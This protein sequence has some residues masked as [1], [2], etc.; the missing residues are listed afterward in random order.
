MHPK[1]PYSS[2][3]TP[4]IKMGPAP[5]RSVDGRL[6]RSLAAPKSRGWFS[7]PSR[8]TPPHFSEA[9]PPPP[10]GG[11][12]I[13]SGRPPPLWRAHRRG[14]GM[15]G[16]RGPDWVGQAAPT[17]PS[18]PGIAWWGDPTAARRARKPPFGLRLPRGG[19]PRR[20]RGDRRQA[21]GASRTAA[22]QSAAMANRAASAA[23]IGARPPAGAD[24]DHPWA[25]GFGCSLFL[26]GRHGVGMPR[27]GPPP[28]TPPQ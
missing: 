4:F 9:W 8:A 24:A 22:A 12:G 27:S 13:G 23:L 11:G 7:A 28:P 26:G 25:I 1:C 20:R 10:R 2:C 3:L 15:A 5:S 21:C 16:W 6:R 18:P 14:L 19:S 17:P